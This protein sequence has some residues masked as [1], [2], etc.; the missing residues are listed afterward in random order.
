MA[1]MDDMRK[2][3]EEREKAEARER[4]GPDRRR[5]DYVGG[6]ARYAPPPPPIKCA[7]THPPRAFTRLP[8][9]CHLCSGLNV[10]NPAVDGIVGRARDAAKKGG[11]IVAD[12]P[13]VKVTFWKNGFVLEDGELRSYDDDAGKRFMADV[14]AGRIPAILNE[15][16]ERLMAA[17]PPRAGAAPE[18]GI[19]ID[20]RWLVHCGSCLQRHGWQQGCFCCYVL[21]ARCTRHPDAAG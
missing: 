12:A 19:H 2:A 9:T 15:Q 16:V 5:E 20:V 21:H 17:A 4:D 6:G 1:T 8:T 13:S 11:D 14:G 10:V 7:T 18:I 3:Q